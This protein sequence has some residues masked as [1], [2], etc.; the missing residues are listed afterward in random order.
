[1]AIGAMFVGTMSS[2]AATDAGGQ[3]LHAPV[4]FFPPAVPASGEII[5]DHAQPTLGR[6]SLRAPVELA[7]YVNESF[8]PALSTRLLAGS[9]GSKLTA[10]LDAYHATRGTL[11]YELADQLVALHNADDETREME[12]RAFAAQQSP[13]IAALESEAEELR[14]ALVEGGVLQRSVDWSRRR[15]WTM[16]VTRFKGEQAEKEAH[17]QVVRAAAF[18]QDG[19]VPEQRGL[20]LEVAAELQIRARAARPVPAPR[21]GD[22]AAMF[23]SPALSRLRLPKNITPVLVEKISRYNRE[24]RTLKDELRDAVFEHDKRSRTERTAA[25]EALADQQWPRFA[26]LEKLAEEIRIGLAALPAARLAAPPHI[27]PGLMRRIE[28]YQRDR[29]KFVEEFAQTLQV[30]SSLVRPP[31]VDFKLSED[32]RVQMARKLAADRAALRAKVADAFQ[33]AT[34][35]RFQAMRERYDAIQA[36]LALVAVGQSDPETGRPFNAETLLRGYFNAVEKFET[37]GREEV[38]YRGYRTAMLMPGLSR[39]QRRL[40]FGAAIV[41]LAQPLPFGETFPTEAQ[42]VPRS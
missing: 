12:L 33:E 9:L 41:G 21:S 14:R 40:L 36:D 27:P 5:E 1:M 18:Y 28:D 16:G 25:F 37:F 6:M 26:E 17:F 4:V 42:P 31:R 34:R 3:R 32:A 29:K 23:F 24:K 19:L 8:Y 20:L 2:R 7:D 30:A 13:R 15:D 35:E 11:I 22:P 10:R 38:I 39:E